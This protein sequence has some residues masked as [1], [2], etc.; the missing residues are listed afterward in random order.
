MTLYRPTTT[1]EHDDF[2]DDWCARCLRY[3]ESCPIASKILTQDVDE[4]IC[5]DTGKPRCAAFVEYK[6]RGQIALFQERR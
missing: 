3:R 5:D 2:F 1:P 6:A 4:V